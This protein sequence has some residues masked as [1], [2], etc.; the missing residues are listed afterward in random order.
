[1]RVVVCMIMPAT[2]PTLVIMIVRMG[3]VMIMMAATAFTVMMVVMVMLGLD[4]S[5]GKPLLDGD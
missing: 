2:A 3:V 4:Q 5:G 1:M